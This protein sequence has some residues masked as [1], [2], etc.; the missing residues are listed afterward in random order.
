M[1]KTSLRK[2]AVAPAVCALL[3]YACDDGGPTLLCG[4]GTVEVEGS[5][6]P[7]EAACGAG[8]SYDE[9]T[10]S[11]LPDVECG[12]GTVAMGTSCVPDGSV[13][14]QNNTIFDMDTG[15]CVPDPDAV[16][17]GDLVYVAETST[18][19]AADSLLPDMADAREG[20]ETNDVGFNEDYIPEILDLSS[21]GASIYGCV[22]PM[23]F[24]GDGVTD[25]DIDHFAVE[26]TEPTLL[27]V[28]ADGLDGVSAAVFVQGTSEALIQ[29]GWARVVA[30]LSGDGAS[31]QIFLPEA[32]LYLLAAT[33]ARSLFFGE[34]AGGTGQCYFT[35]I[36]VETLPTPTPIAPGDTVSGELGAPAFYSLTTTEGMLLFPEL[37]EVDGAGEPADSGAAVSSFVQLID[38][39]FD[40]NAESD[41]GVAGS[42]VLGPSDG[43]TVMWVVDYV[44]NLSVDPVGYELEIVDA[45]AQVM[46]TDGSAVTLTHSDT[47][48]SWVYFP[49]TAG[50]VVHVE[51][52]QP[53]GDLLEVVVFD[54][55]GS[56]QS[57]CDDC[58]VGEAYIQ[59]ADT[60]L[61]YL[62]IFNQDGTDG[63]T[64]DVEFA[65]TALTP[66]PLATGGT[67]SVSLASHSRS[68]FAADL[69]TTDWVELAASGLT[70]LTEVEIVG[71]AI[72]EF[73]VLDGGLAGDFSG[74]VDG[75]D[76]LERIPLGMTGTI[77]VGV[78][79]ADAH[80]GDESFDLTLS[81]VT[82]TD[83][84][85]VD[86]TMPL[87]QAGEMVAASGSNRYLV[88]S[89]N[90][91]DT[92]EVEAT[93][94]DATLDLE[95]EVLEIPG[96]GTDSVINEAGAG[97][98]EMFERPTPAPSAATAFR[99]ND[100]GGTGGTF[101][102]GVTAIEPPYIE[103][104]AM[105]PFVSVCP[106]E[107]GAGTVAVSGDDEFST[108]V[109]V[110]GS[111][112]F[113]GET[114]TELFV[115]TNGWISFKPA[116]SGTSGFGATSY[117]A[118]EGDAIAPF[119]G[120]L[121]LDAVCTER[122]GS[123][124]TVELRGTTYPDFFGESSP[125]EVQAVL[126][127][128]GRIDFVYGAGHGAEASYPSFIG[129]VSPDASVEIGLFGAPAASTAFTLTPR[130]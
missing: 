92:M 1:I 76:T 106:S 83:L 75:V 15:T 65:S 82:F 86:P 105:I 21:G 78:A 90:A 87:A 130:L 35:Q 53:A 69:A 100:A 46:P 74:L 108:A 128:S 70:N 124:L 99:V 88:R 28:Q 64:Y 22:E 119:A 24:D 44:S 58:D 30:S 7:A 94:A 40:A 67:A 39:A 48:R 3:L 45:G 123:T 63:A 57:V 55:E 12:A 129:I 17:E 121:V 38:G 107:G 122:A 20:A 9:A 127:D 62:G 71:Y 18:C 125:V 114:K 42:L 116:N 34:P 16:C 10:R 54:P 101:D 59:I 120:D 36:T 8:T 104:S 112:P 126:H 102:L 103:S 98:S 2:L 56:G 52:T 61:H 109:A 27:T 6:V 4:D 80:D 95:L 5:C 49:A 66:A 96:G 29:A 93:T 50:D 51:F 117:P 37:R 11:C 68:F 72:G 97:E 26:V 31:R 14:C 43:Q 19:V 111:F 25:A 33:D 73:G 81:N 118:G 110:G 77:L 41:G 32:G 115:S 91:G 85:T 60:G 47:A 23:D 89:L 113:F 13:I 79:D 84:G